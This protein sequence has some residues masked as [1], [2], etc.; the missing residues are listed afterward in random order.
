MGD[1]PRGIQVFPD[2]FVASTS[3]SGSQPSQ[4]SSD[5]DFSLGPIATDW[6]EEN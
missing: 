1:G 3:A 4:T 2:H 6:L 5:T